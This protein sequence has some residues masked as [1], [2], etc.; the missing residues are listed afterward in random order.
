MNRDR[1]RLGI[2]RIPTASGHKSITDLDPELH[3]VTNQRIA[4][5]NRADRLRR[6]RNKKR[7][8]YR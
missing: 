4:A 7:K 2:P 5:I 1:D 8:S 3:H 6:R